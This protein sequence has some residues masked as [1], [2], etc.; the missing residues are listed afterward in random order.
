MVYG[1]PEDS[2]AVQL[3][4]LEYMTLDGGLFIRSV[5]CILYQVSLPTPG[6]ILWKHVLVHSEMSYSCEEPDGVRGNR[7]WGP[8]IPQI[9][10]VC[11]FTFCEY[12]NLT[13]QVSYLASDG[14]PYGW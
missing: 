4:T 3:H 2:L 13:N 14:S 8:P 10:Y 11:D 9:V 5:I 1:I 6:D 12:V 7:P